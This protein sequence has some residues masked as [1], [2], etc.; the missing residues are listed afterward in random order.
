MG[1]KQD[2]QH[3]SA[4]QK[5]ERTLEVRGMHCASCSSAVERALN[6]LSEVDSA[7]VNLLTGQARV[8]LHASIS[9]EKLITAVTAAGY[10]AAV[11]SSATSPTGAEP[12]PVRLRIE[13]MHCASCA[14]AVELAL[15]QTAG[16]ASATVNPAT[17]TAEVTLDET[18]ASV[19]QLVSAV[20][21]AGYTAI[22]EPRTASAALARTDHTAEELAATRRRM[23]IAWIAA[24]PIIGWMIPE[25]L[26]GIM[27]PSPLVFHVGM[28]VLAAPALFLAG[29]PT[30][31]A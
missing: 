20:S 15:R 17:S 5:Q 29:W 8:V 14:S 18:M 24:V 2:R 16:V 26:F 27:W 11:E 4:K 12:E 13:G 19:P 30:L 7:A 21:R 23:V 28:V 9:D 1:N 31:R 6:D 3:Q 10:E 25:M 22:Y